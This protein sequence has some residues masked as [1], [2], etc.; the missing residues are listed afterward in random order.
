MDNWERF[1][2]NILPNKKAFYRELNLEDIANKDYVYAQKLFEE[3]KLKNLGD[4]HDLYVQSD[5]LFLLDVFEN[6]INKCIKIYELD[7]AYFLFAPGWAWQACFKKTGVKLELL[8]DIDM[9]LI[10]EKGIRGVIFH[11]IRR[12]A[13]ANNKYMKTYDKNTAT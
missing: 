12:Y 7:P 1:N 10:V 9:L 11:A 3:S 4:Y 8:T 5:M 2:E 13:K 6:F